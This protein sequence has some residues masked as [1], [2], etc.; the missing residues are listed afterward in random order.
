MA[1]HGLYAMFESFL[2]WEM[3]VNKIVLFIKD[4]NTWKNEITRGIEA[5]NDISAIIDKVM[6]FQRISNLEEFQ[7]DPVLNQFD[8][9]IPVLHKQTPIAYAIIGGFEEE[10]DM[11]N[12]V[13]FITTITNVIAV[14]IENK[15]LFKKQLEQERLKRELELASDMQRLLIPRN[16]PKTQSFEFS[17]V[18]KPQLGVGGDYYDYVELEDGR[19]VCCVADISGKGVAAALL[20][21]NF[22]AIFHSAL[23]LSMPLDSLVIELNQALFRI[24]KGEKYLTLFVVEINPA[25]KEIC[26]VNAGHY[27]PRLLVGDELIQL[28]K[29]CTIL[30]MFEEIPTIEVGRQTNL[31]ACTL[32]MFTD[33]LTDITDGKGAFFDEKRIDKV[34][35]NNKKASPDEINEAIVNAIE[36][37]KG[38]QTYPDDITILTCRVLPASKQ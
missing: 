5:K 28:D 23:K 26:Y 14:A 25:R 32:L 30:G 4:Q 22:Q 36:E 8:F 1:A 7:D 12:K 6:D 2:S 33:G 13:Q 9:V 11:Y 24:T 31:E 37:F 3:G 35:R 38:T 20:M 16:L 19:M 29:G 10:E 34:M 18:Y 17:S 21:A 15:R 27:P